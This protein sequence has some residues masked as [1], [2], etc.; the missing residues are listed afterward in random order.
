[1][2]TDKA[3]ESSKSSFFKF[4]NKTTNEDSPALSP[5]ALAE[6]PQEI[7]VRLISIEHEYWNKLTFMEQKRSLLVS[8]LEISDEPVKVTIN[9]ELKKLDLEIEEYK[10]TKEVFIFT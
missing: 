3:V 1:M 5:V 9:D 10:S 4:F 6:N 7:A 8:K 2:I